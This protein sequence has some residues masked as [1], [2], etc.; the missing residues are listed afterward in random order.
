MAKSFGSKQKTVNLFL[1]SGDWTDDE[2]TQIITLFLS[3]GKKWS[4]IAKILGGCRTEHMVKNRYKAILSK[5]RRQYPS[6]KVDEKLMRL[7]L[8]PSTCVE[9]SKK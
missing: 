6:I 2:D 5:Q 7:F 9:D 4:K 8:D 3:I 1:F